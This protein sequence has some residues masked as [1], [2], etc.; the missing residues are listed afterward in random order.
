MMNL[1]TPI[2]KEL[3]RPINPSLYQLKDFTEKLEKKNS[4]LTRVMAQD[5]I[6]V[7]GDADAI[8]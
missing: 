3:Q 5:K 1:L 6:N 8:G 7:I 2:E 4:F